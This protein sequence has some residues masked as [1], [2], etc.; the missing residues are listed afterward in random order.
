MLADE[1]RCDRVEI[2]LELGHVLLADRQYEE[3]SDAYYEATEIDPNN[4]RAWHLQGYTFGELE[5]YEDAI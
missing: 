4:A 1:D 2:F 3:A 5:E